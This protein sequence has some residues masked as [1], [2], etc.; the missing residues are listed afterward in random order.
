ML[1]NQ[2]FTILNHY[3]IRFNH[4]FLVGFTITFNLLF[5]MSF[6]ISSF[7][8]FLI[9]ERATKA[10]HVQFVSGV[11]VVTFWLSAFLWDFI[12]YMLPCG[13]IMLVLVA[14]DVEAYTGGIRLL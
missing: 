9:R 11:H 5:G 6:L 4:P 8:L 12:N 13:A 10:K 14:F 2:P 3:S 1:V 7:A